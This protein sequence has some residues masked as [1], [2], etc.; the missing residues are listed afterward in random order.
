MFPSSKDHEESYKSSFRNVNFGNNKT[1]H[2]YY[3]RNGRQRRPKFLSF[4]FVW[5][6]VYY[7]VVEIHNFVLICKNLLFFLFTTKINKIEK[8][9][10]SSVTPVCMVFKVTQKRHLSSYCIIKEKKSWSTEPNMSNWTSL[11]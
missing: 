9:L 6:K 8:A 1:V 4:N 3:C 7:S 11:K 5:R 2:F 10:G